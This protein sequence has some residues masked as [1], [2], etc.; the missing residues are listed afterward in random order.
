MGAYDHFVVGAVFER[1]VEGERTAAEDALVVAV[2]AQLLEQLAYVEDG[3]PVTRERAIEM[4][5]HWLR[6]H[7]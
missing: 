2:G 1:R 7:V 5:E 4:I 3:E 6:Y